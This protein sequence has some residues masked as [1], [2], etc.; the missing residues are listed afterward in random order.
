MPRWNTLRI[1]KKQVKMKYCWRKYEL[2]RIQKVCSENASLETNTV[3]QAFRSELEQKSTVFQICSWIVIE[4]LCAWFANNGK[5]TYEFDALI[6]HFLPS[7]SNTKVATPSFPSRQNGGAR[8]SKRQYVAAHYSFLRRVGC[9]KATFSR[10]SRILNHFSTIK[11][12]AKQFTVSKL[13]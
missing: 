4:Y 2:K 9:V 7:C 5:S 10:N 6:C 11:S 12:L 8:V 1:N 13:P 3:K